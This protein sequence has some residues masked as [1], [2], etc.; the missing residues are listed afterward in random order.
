MSKYLIGDLV[1]L[2]NE[3]MDIEEPATIYIVTNVDGYTDIELFTGNTITKYDYE[4]VMVFP[5]TSTSH[6]IYEAEDNLLLQAK[7]DSRESKLIID[8]IKKDY[9]KKGYCGEPRFLS[10]IRKR[11]AR[12]GSSSGLLT[13]P[14]NTKVAKMKRDKVR[15]NKLETVDE[16]LDAIIHLQE[17]HKAFG[18]KEYLD[19]I[20]IVKKRLKELS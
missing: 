3:D 19:N 1:S 6:F 4:L 5:V 20:E 15:Y 8:F 7:R 13:A 12:S 2:K 18:D 11:I 14:N 9:K 16:C 17:L 10:I